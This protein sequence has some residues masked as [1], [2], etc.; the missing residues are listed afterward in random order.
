MKLLFV[1]SLIK[2]KSIPRPIQNLMIKKVLIFVNS[3]LYYFKELFIDYYIFLFHFRLKFV[4]KL[5]IYMG[6][7]C[8]KILSHL[9]G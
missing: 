3:T 2:L 4:R 5:F 9:K 8:K 7:I 6:K 1:S